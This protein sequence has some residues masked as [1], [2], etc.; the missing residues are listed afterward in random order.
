MAHSRT[1][2]TPSTPTHFGIKN[3]TKK[4][5]K[6]SEMEKAKRAVNTC[7]RV[8]VLQFAPPPPTLP[9]QFIVRISKDTFPALFGPELSPRLY[10]PAVAE[11]AAH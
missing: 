2:G 11:R 8:A 10:R 5:K 7:R 9:P 6:E 1:C 4:K 3:D